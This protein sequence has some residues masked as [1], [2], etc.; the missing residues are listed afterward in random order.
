VFNS[1]WD[2]AL[3]LRHGVPTPLTFRS[4]DEWTAEFMEH[5]LRIVGVESYRPFWPTLGTYHHTMFALEHDPA[6]A[7]RRPASLD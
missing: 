5:G 3:N 6:L 2:K 1:V 7:G 4:I